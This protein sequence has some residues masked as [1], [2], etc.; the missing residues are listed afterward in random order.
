MSANNSYNMYGKFSARHMHS[1]VIISL[2]KT[3]PTVK[4]GENNSPDHDESANPRPGS[5]IAFVLCEYT[6][7]V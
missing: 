5:G 1:C 3:A 4:L 6:R 7:F 2:N